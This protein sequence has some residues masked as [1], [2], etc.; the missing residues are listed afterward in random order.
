MRR[1]EGDG[2]RSEVGGRYRPS[3]VE[4]GCEVLSFGE[5]GGV[6]LWLGKFELSNCVWREGL[7]MY[8]AGRG[9]AFIP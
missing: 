6:K 7:I 5:R 8:V 2:A 9:L 3:R 4:E 1:M